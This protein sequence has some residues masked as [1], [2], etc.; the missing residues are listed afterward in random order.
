MREHNI[1]RQTHKSFRYWIWWKAHQLNVWIISSCKPDS[2]KSSLF[3]YPSPLEIGRNK[4]KS[5][6]AVTVLFVLVVV[7]RTQR[8]PFEAVDAGSILKNGNL[9][10][11][12]I[13]CAQKVDATPTIKA[14]RSCYRASST[15]TVLAAPMNKSSTQ[16]SLSV[17]EQKSSIDDNFKS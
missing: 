4:M 5:W 13:K 6:L 8:L 2:P 7:T 1:T 9:I 11:K 15:K 10:G 14:W 12:H 3:K 17:F 16:I